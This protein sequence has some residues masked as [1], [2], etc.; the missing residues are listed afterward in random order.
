MAGKFRH[1]ALLC[2]LCSIALAFASPGAAAQSDGSFKVRVDVELATAQV[3]VLDKKGNPVPNLK[4]EDF[5]LY[6]DGEKQEILSIDEVNAESRLSSLGMNPLAENALHGG[7]TVLIIFDDSA[8][9]PQY[10]KRYTNIIKN[11]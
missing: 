5:E 6:E 9:M 1:I 7:K 11:Y 8:I 4:K 2:C 3:A 10:I